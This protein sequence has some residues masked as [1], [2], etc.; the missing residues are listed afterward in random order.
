MTGASVVV[1][2][3]SNGKRVDSWSLNDV[4]VQPQVLLSILS[5]IMNAVMSYAL[6]EGIAVFF[7]RQAGRGTTVS[8][9]IHHR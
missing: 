6:I 9:L 7:W 5:T 4:K 8:R 3:L 2:I 1:L